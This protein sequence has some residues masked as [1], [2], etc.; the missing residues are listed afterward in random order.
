M[1]M[2]RTVATNGPSTLYDAIFGNKK[3]YIAPQYIHKFGQNGHFFTLWPKVTPKP[4]VLDD[5]CDRIRF[6]RQKIYKINLPSFL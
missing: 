5:F 4:D 3:R 2:I 1:A 6:Q